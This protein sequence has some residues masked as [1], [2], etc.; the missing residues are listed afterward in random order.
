[1]IGQGSDTLT[2]TYGFVSLVGA[3]PGHPD[4]L[5]VLAVDRL[6]K[7][8]LV[9]YDALVAPEIVVLAEGAQRFCVGKPGTHNRRSRT[10]G[11]RHPTDAPR[12]GLRLRR[13][14]GTRRK[15]LSPCPC[16][17]HAQHA[18][19]GGVDGAIKSAGRLHLP[20]EARVATRHTR[21]GDLRS[22]DASRA[23][24]GR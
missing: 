11:S 10:C 6:R 14:L 18:H 16:L 9:L 3:G 4:L 24:L 5:T 15:E 22:V 7:A 2:M 13:R 19:G 21:C 12:V 17:A 8:D 20:A 23:D 1:M